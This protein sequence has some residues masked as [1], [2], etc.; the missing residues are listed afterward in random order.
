MAIFDNQTDDSIVIADEVD[1]GFVERRV[2]EH[3]RFRCLSAAPVLAKVELRQR[4]GVFYVT[5]QCR[6][7]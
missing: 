4:E 3:V 5:S 1:A 2:E 6:D 7:A